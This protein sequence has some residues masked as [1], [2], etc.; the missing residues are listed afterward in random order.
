M[1][2]INKKKVG[3]VAYHVAD[4]GDFFGWNVG[5]AQAGFGALVR[6]SLTS[7]K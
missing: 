3:S 2:E 7:C 6:S 5:L 4:E 1:S